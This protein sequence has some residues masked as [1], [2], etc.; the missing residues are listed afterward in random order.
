MSNLQVNEISSKNTTLI[1][2]N[3]I[4]IGM[5]IPASSTNSLVVTK[6][7]SLGNGYYLSDSQN[8]S[9]IGYRLPT[10]TTPTRYG[11]DISSEQTILFFG[12][13]TEKM[14]ITQSGYVGINTSTPQT[15]LGISGFARTSISTTDQ[16]YKT[17]LVTKDYLETRL[18]N[19]GKT[20]SGSVSWVPGLNSTT[21]L[22]VR[23][24]AATYTRLSE[25][26]YRI[27]LP[28]P[29]NLLTGSLQANGHWYKP[30]VAEVQVWVPETKINIFKII[31]AHWAVQTPYQPA[32][33]GVL[34]ISHYYDVSGEGWS[35][36]S[37]RELYNDF[38]T[39]TPGK[40]VITCSDADTG[41]L[42]D[43]VQLN[44][45]LCPYLESAGQDNYD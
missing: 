31:P 30:E 4:G 13:D 5:S 3:N 16:S 15:A 19:Q 40:F 35:I 24:V 9:I 37:S 41:E 17:T 8:N 22:C 21:V 36:E 29:Y 23:G 26:I 10:T 39:I 42:V 33:R 44:W 28:A 34:T 11:V 38:D 45:A 14:R 12:G 6:G 25:G 2:N 1:I 43:P 32:T 18:L 27:T 7:I 20:I